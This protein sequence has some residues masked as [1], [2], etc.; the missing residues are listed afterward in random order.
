MADHPSHQHA[1]HH[2]PHGHDD[3]E[4]AVS[5][6]QSLNRLA[7]SATL[8]CLTGCGIG[9]A[10]GLVIANTLHWSNTASILLAVVLAFSFGYALSLRPLLIAGMGFAAAAKVAFVADT[11]SI[12]V[13]EFV[14]NA[15][16]LLIPGAMNASLGE[17]LFWTSLVLSLGG[18]F[19][20]AYPVNRWLI[21]RG[22][23]HA[24]MHQHHH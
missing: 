1:H 2:P 16:M 9:E 8:H 11:V 5:T 23:G 4:S 24:V 19:V 21:A 17:P 18:A 6:G 3:R 22:Q 15:I 20:A 7:L 10:L 14:D 13:M 12:T